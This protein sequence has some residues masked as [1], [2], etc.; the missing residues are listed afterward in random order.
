MKPTGNLSLRRF[1]VLLLMMVSY[2][3]TY[4]LAAPKGGQVVS[5]TASFQQ[6]GNLTVITAGNRSVINYGSFNIAA[7]ETVKF[8]QPGAS[9]SV[10]NRVVGSA[11][12]T[13]IFGSLQANGHVFIVN[14]YGIYF[15]NGSVIN[16]GGLYAGAGNLSDADF[17]KGKIHF[18]DLAGDVR[19]DGIII[20]DNHIALMGANVVNTGSLK[21]NAGLAMMVS[22][23]E[24]YVGEKNGNIFVQAN[25]NAAAAPS[26]ASGSVVNRG[27]VAAPRVLLGGGDLYSTAISNSGLLQG[28]NIVVNAGRS[29]SATVGG[30]V[31]ASSAHNRTATG[32]GGSIRVL[33]GTVAL[34]GAT[35]DATGEN[36]GGSVRVGGDFHGAG[37]LTRAATTTVDAGTTIK[38]DAT[39]TT[40]DGGTVVLWSDT[41]TS[42]SGA[43]SVAG[44]VRSGNGGQVEVSSHGDLGFNGT[45]NAAAPGGK[46][47]SLL[48]DPTNIDI[49]SGIGADAVPASGQIVATDATPTT[50]SA[51]SLELLGG[52]VNIDLEATQDIRIENLMLRLDGGTTPN[53][54]N[55]A[56]GTGSVTLRAGVGGTGSFVMMNST[57]TG[58]GALALPADT[59]VAPGRAVTISA[60]GPSGANGIN[61][62]STNAIEVGNINTSA[63]TG[64]GAINLLI[65]GTSQPA[66]APVVYSALNSSSTGAAGGI[67]TIGGTAGLPTSIAAGTL[68]TA[69][70][71][72]TTGGAINLQT[73]A[74]GTITFTA[75]PTFTG[76]TTL[77]A[78]SFSVTGGG[79]LNG[80]NQDLTLTLGSVLNLSS[81]A[82][83][84]VRN[85]FVNG[86]SAAS[87]TNVDVATFATSGSQKYESGVTVSQNTTLR[88]TNNS[89][90]TFDGAV[91]SSNTGGT[92]DARTL[93]LASGGTTRFNVGVGSTY[94]LGG[95][96]TDSDNIA[97][98]QTIF[99]V[100]TGPAVTT[101]NNGTATGAQTY[102]DDVR[103]AAD[104]V[105]LSSA[106]GTNL[107]GA[108]TFGRTVASLDTTAR[109]L[110][111]NNTGTTTFGGAVGSGTGL[112]AL[113]SFSTGSG[114][115]NLNG[116]AV[117]TNNP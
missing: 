68:N 105:L 1:C 97:T 60:N 102:N 16:V 8:V 112:T 81:I 62:G 79:T 22:G 21:S 42:D 58:I 29:G 117:T 101:V 39:G 98:G 64:G 18:T 45:V 104:T 23:K 52:G 80:G 53:V 2:T 25:G 49:T 99:N 43:I 31:D 6:N 66:A 7:G 91:N 76:A 108:M 78:E 26:A 19:N 57:P 89:D 114:T 10:L 56:A 111:I 73:T 65:S 74:A 106:T 70:A 87:G 61:G 15:R 17:T 46:P 20:A 100:T 86:T 115:T 59:I 41:R 40:G 28:R 4:V 71:T 85:L 116:G 35:L 113:S 24:V 82:S 11:N 107:G 103:L 67:V 51:H 3:D 72:A 95:L 30:T 77:I 83:A 110:G 94:A 50:I 96:I 5:G 69:G 27:T 84:S 33:G 44:G 14:P 36:G 9:S 47:G 48:L 88:A 13:E 109:S 32:T 12:P 38:A 92:T 54:L 93:S 63:A 34:K 75:A 37:T 90:L 55:L